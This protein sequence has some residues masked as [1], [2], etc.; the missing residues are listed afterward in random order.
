[1]SPVAI[2][3]TS[4]L[5]SDGEYRL[6]SISLDDARYFARHSEGFISAI[7]HES[8]AAIL[9]ELLGV[10]VPV[11]RIQFA[12]VP[13]Q[14]ALVFKLRGRPAEGRILS[15]EEIEAIGYDFKILERVF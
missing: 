4:I 8:T 15:K 1:M 9:T 11:N 6:E 12:Q 7:G 2:L 10:P 13:G 5:T 3:N 14:L